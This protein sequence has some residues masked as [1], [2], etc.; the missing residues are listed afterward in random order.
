M[1]E[2][3]FSVG[4]VVFMITVYGA[5]VVGGHLLE[6]MQLADAVNDVGVPPIHA[7]RSSVS[8]APPEPV[9]TQGL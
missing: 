9:S 5:L 6:N 2:L 8:T 1:T 7:P 3:L 4:I